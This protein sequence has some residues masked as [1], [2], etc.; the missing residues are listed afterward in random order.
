MTGDRRDGFRVRARLASALVVLIGACS[1][2]SP[3]T[4]VSSSTL[5]SSTTGIASAKTSADWPLPGQN[6]DNARAAI[7]GRIT[8]ATV[9]HLTVAFKAPV[10]GLGALSTAPLVVG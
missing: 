7:G 9:K 5:S 1:S 6:Y 3:S 2:A 4:V 10:P 8:R